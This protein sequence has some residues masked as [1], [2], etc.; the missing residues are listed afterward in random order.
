M[1]NKVVLASFLVCVIIL[2]I[3]L[4]LI[5]K[6]PIKT[7]TPSAPEKE[8]IV[9]EDK[10]IEICSDESCE[11]KQT[12]TYPI[13]K[14]DLKIDEVQEKIDK[15]NEQTINYYEE[16]ENN[17][18]IDYYTD[19]D[20]Y[21]DKS[22]VSIMLRRTKT[23]LCTNEITHL[24]PVV[25]LYDKTE[26]TFFSAK[27]LFH[28]KDITNEQVQKAIQKNI[29]LNNKFSNTNFA[30]ENTYQDGKQNLKAYYTS[31]GELYISYK[32]NENGTY[33]AALL[34]Y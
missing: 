16:A 8:F 25:Y 29:D 1:K 21:N 30:I 24:E 19:Y 23:N 17:K 13:I 31:L 14:I 10:T 18:C 28:K 32:Q 15:I 12:R 6:E 22:Y 11:L 7:P 5:E 26:R 20:L 34:E 3:G 2:L 33:H 27:D 9:T 4:K